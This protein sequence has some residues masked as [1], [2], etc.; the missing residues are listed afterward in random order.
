M[1]NC[2]TQTTITNT[3]MAELTRCLVCGCRIRIGRL[4][5]HL[6]RAH[7]MGPVAASKAIAESR[8]VK[9]RPDVRASDKKLAAYAE[10][11]KSAPRKCSVENCQALVIPPEE[12]C[13]SCKLKR[14]SQSVG[15]NPGAQNLSGHRC[16]AC[17]AS[18]VV[19]ENYC[20]SCLGD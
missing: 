5:R 1:I 11:L 9:K 10:R 8:T 2:E 18:A 19:G 3:A 12:F 6:Q 14:M 15:L 16:E 4:N 13:D 7:G 20:Y 17:G